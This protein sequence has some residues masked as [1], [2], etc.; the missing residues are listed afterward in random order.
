[1][2]F[3]INQTFNGLS[4]AALLF[5]MA[6][7]LSLIFGVMKIVNIAQ[8]SFFLV[9]GYIGYTVVN[10][11]GN[12]YLGF[13]SACIVMGLLGVSLEHIFLEDLAG[14]NLRM[15]LTTMGI[16]LFFQDLSLLIWGG[17]PLNLPAPEYLTRILK[18]GRFN[19]ATFRLFMIGAAGVLFFLLWSLQKRTRM[20]SM[21]R[22]AVD[23][24]EI[25]EGLGINVTAMKMG[26]F[27]LGA[28]LSAFGGVIGCSYMA[29]YPG[30]D[31]EL[32]PYAFVV[33]VV[34]G[35]GSL[36]GALV[37]SII[38]G[39]TDNFGKALFPE[40][41]YFTLFAPMALVLAWRPIGLFGRK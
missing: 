36:S 9:G 37:G 17:N 38:V 4:Y 15:M 20:G 39:I 7:G 30:L 23:N 26:V 19:F 41:A 10:G 40:L 29:L 25:A 11:T 14:D 24:S 3:L 27:G 35:M 8:G 12:F 22:A 28:A 13:L 6:G 32:L 31:F 18:V 2:E 33:V 21:V 16:A 1:M 5:L 34:G